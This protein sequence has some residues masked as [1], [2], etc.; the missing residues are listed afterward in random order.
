M[1]ETPVITAEAA[2]HTIDVPQG[3]RGKRRRRSKFPYLLVG[4]YTIFLLGFGVAPALYAVY[5]S[6]FSPTNTGGTT[7]A[8][9]RT[10][11]AMLTD[12]RLMPAVVNVAT[13]L[14]IWL[15]TLLVVVFVLALIMHA[16]PSKFTGAMRFVYYVPGAVTGSAAAL[17]WL[18]MWSPSVSPFSPVL[19]L[20]G[21]SSASQAVQGHTAV[22]IAIMGVAIHAGGWILIVYG[23]LASLPKEVLEAAMID[24]ASGWSLAVRVKLPMIKPYLALVVITTFAAGTQVFV[25]PKVLSTG[26][27]GQVSQTWSLNELAYYF[28]TQLQNFGAAAALSLLLLLVGLIIALL[29]IFRTKFYDVDAGAK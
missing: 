7:F 6:L 8:P 27:A 2:S 18:F 19:K 5:L 4:L 20:F 17:L 22:V 21:I 3:W 10:W 13:Y 11:Q 15:P 24:G 1:N 14:V 12:Y 29:V 9:I 16:R 25:E 26:V 23:G 28:A